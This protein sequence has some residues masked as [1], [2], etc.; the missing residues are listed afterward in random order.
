V[1]GEQVVQVNEATGAVTTYYLRQVGDRWRPVEVHGDCACSGNDHV[2]H[3]DLAGN[4]ILE[5]D[6]RGYLTR[7]TYTT[8]GR[9]A[10]EERGLMRVACDP[11]ASSEE[12]SPCLLDADALAALEPGD[13][14]SSSAA[15]VLRTSQTWTDRDELSTASPRARVKERLDG[16]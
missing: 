9:R 12:P 4:V 16:A 2:Y 15:T 6:A 13:I 14:M 10:G 7:S 5:Q 3:Y 8:D 11:A 1:P